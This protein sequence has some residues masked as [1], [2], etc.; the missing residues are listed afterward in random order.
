M[1]ALDERDRARVVMTGFAKSITTI[2]LAARRIR[3]NSGGAPGSS[4]AAATA[5]SAAGMP[6]QRMRGLF[7]SKESIPGAR[8]IVGVVWPLAKRS[9]LSIDSSNRALAPLAPVRPCV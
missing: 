3:E 4:P 2:A 6:C 8:R 5:M 1:P 9:R 7:N